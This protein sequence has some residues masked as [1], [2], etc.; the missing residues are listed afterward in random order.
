VK[1]IEAGLLTDGSSYSPTPS[2]RIDCQW[3][4]LLAFVPAHSGA[5]VRELHPLP[6]SSTSIARVSDVDRPLPSS[7]T[8]VKQIFFPKCLPG[9]YYLLDPSPFPPDPSNE[10]LR[11][12]NPNADPQG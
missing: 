1:A 10:T 12:C 3:L 9:C 8:D 5:P 2:R 7:E 4:I 11:L 6:A